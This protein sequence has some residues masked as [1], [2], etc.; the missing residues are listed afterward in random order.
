MMTASA[1]HMKAMY[2][3][4][5]YAVNTPK[6]SVLLN[7]NAKW[8]GNPSVEFEIMGNETECQER[9]VSGYATF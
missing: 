6:R 3:V 7:P 2:R 8:N 9:S 1:A 5:V 4:M